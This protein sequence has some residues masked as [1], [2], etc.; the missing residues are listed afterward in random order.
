[1]ELDE[2]RLAWQDMGRQLERQQELQWE[3]LRG[4]RLDRVRS[5]LR[6]LAWGQVLQV[7][8]GI[9][10]VVLGI[11]CWSRNTGNTTL[12]TTGI[13]VHV[14]GVVNIVLAGI[15]LG[16]IRRIDYA[17]PVLSIQ[18]RSERLLRTYLFNGKVCGLGWWLMWLPVTLAV[19][20]LAR[21]D[22]T[23]QAPA[24][25]WSGLAVSVVG[26]VATWA[27]LRRA[28]ARYRATAATSGEGKPLGDG[29]DGIRRG[30]RLLADLERFG[31][32]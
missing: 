25:V 5:H 6:P 17:A 16:R 11:A 21:I 1:M 18:K 32:D 26:L 22:L 8:F 24:Y 20:G 13:A 29:A 23:V 4:H 27:F 19:A 9:A 7:L 15:T 14:F 2:L 31:R 3:L 12:F 28:E 10:L 30:Q